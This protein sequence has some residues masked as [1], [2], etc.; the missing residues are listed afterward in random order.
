VVTD[1]TATAN[2]VRLYAINM[3]TLGVARIDT[4]GVTWANPT[5][6]H[7]GMGIQEVFYGGSPGNDVYSWD[8]ATST[9]DPAAN[10]RNV[11]EL[12]DSLS[13]GAGEVARDFAFKGKEVVEY[14]GDHF[15]PA[16]AIRFQTWE[17]GQGYV[18]GERV[19]RKASV[20][21]ETYWRSYRCLASHTA[22]S[23]NA[24]GTGADTATYWQKVRL[25]LPR[26]DDDETSDKW[27]FVPTAPGSSV[28]QWHASRFWIRY[29]GQGNKSRVLFSAPVEPE[30][31]ADIPDVT[32]D[33]TDFAPGN[34]LLGPGGGWLEFNDGRKEGVVEAMWSY[35]TYLLVFKRQAVFTVTGFSEDTFTVRRLSRHVGAV[36]PECVQELNGLVYFLSDDG[37]YVTDGTSVEPVINNDRIRLWLADRI[38]G[39]TAEGSAGDGRNPTLQSFG[40]R[41][42]ISLPDEDETEKHVTLVYD[43]A[44]ASFWKLDLPALVLQSARHFGVQHLY[45]AAPPT[46]GGASQDLVFEYDHAGAADE[47]DTA[48]ADYAT[49]EIPWHMRTTWWPFGTHHEDRRIRRTWALVKGAMT[50]TLRWYR[51]WNDSDTDTV[52]RAITGTVPKNV[53][54]EW[55]PD[56]RAIAFRLSSDRA[57]ATVY[58]F[59]VETQRRRTRRY[60]RGDIS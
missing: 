23:T 36:G 57:P 35:G 51:N 50:Y 10:D 33:M 59:T 17:D 58:G 32:F 1:E 48:A 30:K 53:E 43:P 38:D 39:M 12:V 60:H 28:A 22:A 29:D 21:G 44:N 27:Y 47:D 26:N 37:L 8:P 40:Q 16:K 55:V 42:W 3:G 24:P 7:W 14:D 13:P 52:T 11:D 9:W 2:N 15:T 46:Y 54:G 20:G 45:F 49:Q 6:D 4:S 25:P 31:G 34:D 56:A 18:V 41:L 5:A 19:S